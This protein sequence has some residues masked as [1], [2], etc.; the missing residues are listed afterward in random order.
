MLNVLV[1]I[2]VV[3]CL[4]KD[5]HYRSNHEWFYALHL[6]ADKVDFGSAEDDIKEAYFLGQRAMLPPS[7]GEIRKLVAERIVE[8]TGDNKKLIMRLANA[9]D[10][11]LYS[12]EEAKREPGMF[13]GVHAILDGI[14]QTALT[15][16]GLC[17]R[18]LNNGETD[19]ENAD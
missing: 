2:E 8:A 16:K 3:K 5:M 18:T 9:C 10:M 4:A 19:N 14:S 12:I 6:L 15:I 1:A 17:W 13:A 11:L 7:E